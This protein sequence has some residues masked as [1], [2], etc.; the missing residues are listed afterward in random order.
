MPKFNNSLMDI[1]LISVIIPVYNREKY[2]LEAIE[3]ILK[4]TIQS[5]EI[6]IIDDGSTDKSL[7]LIKTCNDPRIVVIENSENIGVSLSRN[8][9]LDRAL[10]TYIAYMDSDDISHPKR[11]EKQLKVLKSNPNIDACGCWLQCFGTNSKIIE[12]KK[13]H[14]EIQ[15]QL[16]LSNSMSLG[17]TMVK[18]EAFEKYRF[19][20]AKLHVEDY[21]YW[22]RSAWNCKFYNLQEVLY[23]YRTHDKQVSNMYLQIQ[24]EQDVAIKMSLIKKVVSKEN[25]ISD[26]KLKNI[27]FTNKEMCLDGFKDFYYWIDSFRVENK[28]QRVYDPIELKKTLFI[29]RR[30]LVFQ[31][32][33]LNEREGLT[34]SKR[35]NIFW[36]LPIREKIY[37]FKKKLRERIKFF[38]KRVSEIIN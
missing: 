3:S 4:Q 32:F 33:F 19:D 2:I 31:T 36:L 25:R 35:G 22:A 16:I 21:D 1:P 24:R 6:I 8:K 15:A 30:I 37:V 18:K 27:L 26:L 13:Y 7:K 38:L 12:Y 10:G 23:Y 34:K 5:F 20:P 28:W 9:A 14:G 29:L 17:A 11:F